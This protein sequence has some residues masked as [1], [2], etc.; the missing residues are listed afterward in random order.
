MDDITI[1]VRPFDSCLKNLYQ[2]VQRYIEKWLVL[3]LEKHHF[4]I[5]GGIFLGHIVTKKWDSNRSNQCGAKFKVVEC[6]FS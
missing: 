3:N 2:V 1:Y 6:P 5:K 4:V